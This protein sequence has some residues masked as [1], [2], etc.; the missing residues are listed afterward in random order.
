MN[1]L[2]LLSEFHDLL[3]S[4][5]DKLAREKSEEQKQNYT[6]ISN[7]L[8]EEA[9]KVTKDKSKTY[10]GISIENLVKTLDSR[11]SL[12]MNWKHASMTLDVRLL[13][14]ITKHSIKEL[15]TPYFVEELL[16]FDENIGF[17]F[18]NGHINK[19]RT[20][21]IHRNTVHI[22]NNTFANFEKLEQ[23]QIEP[24]SRLVILGEG[25]FSYCPKLQSL[26]LRNCKEL[27]IIPDFII[28]NSGVKVLK[29]SSHINTICNKAF[30]KADELRYVGLDNDTYTID[31]FKTNMELNNGKPFWIEKDIEDNETETDNNRD[32][33][34]ETEKDSEEINSEEVE[35]D[36]NF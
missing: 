5:S 15:N 30:T 25:A 23:V 13:V 29:I 27:N 1:T 28:A 2:A 26:D 21:K 32:D 20:V 10:S 33:S 34:E 12:I 7:K 35:D 31:E 9:L 24:E 17:G 6:Y 22:A 36:Y 19:I 11:P 16:P 18:N 14:D 4:E 3:E 8:L